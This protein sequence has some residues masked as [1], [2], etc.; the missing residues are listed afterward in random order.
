MARQVLPWVGAAVGF[1][2]S[3]GNPMGAQ[4]GFALGS[5]IGN[6]VDPIEVQGNKLGDSPTQTAAEGGARAIVFGKGCIRSTCVLERGGRRVIKQRDSSGGKGGSTTTV[7][8]RAL[9]TYA[10]GLGEAIPGGAILRIWEDEKLVYDVTPESQIPDDSAAFAQKFRFYDGSED[11][12]P[13]PAIEAIYSDPDDAPYYRGTAYMVF[14]QRD[15]TDFGERVPMYRVEVATVAN[16]TTIGDS[17]THTYT[18]SGHYRSSYIYPLANGNLGYAT[19]AD[20]VPSDGTYK[21]GELNSSLSVVNETDIAWS[22]FTFGDERLWLRGINEAGNGVSADNNSGYC[23][24]FTLGGENG[25]FLPA[26]GAANSWWYAEENYSPEFGGLVWFYGGSLYLGVRKTGNDGAYQRMLIRFDE[27]GGLPRYPSRVKTVGSSEGPFF[28]MTMSR[29]GLVH[30]IEQDGTYRRFNAELDEVESKPIGIGVTDLRG[31][32]V[33][34]DVIAMIYGAVIPRVE[35]RNIVTGALIKTIN[36]SNFSGNYAT[37][38][39]FTSNSCFIQCREWVGRIPYSRSVVASGVPL[40]DVISAIHQRAGHTPNDYDVGELVELIDGVV[41]EQT[42]TAA[43]A[44]NSIIGTHWADPTE[45]DGKIRY[46][47][48]GKPVVRTLTADD[49]IDEPETWQR[50]N[51]IEY[52]AKVHFFGQIAEA[53]YAPIKA[54]SSRSS[55]DIC[56]NVV[57]EA[58]ISSPETFNDSVRPYEIATIWHKIIW[59]EAGGEITWRVTDEHM[60]LVPSDC[61]GL[62]WRGQLARARIVQIEDDPGERKL[63]MRLDRQSA[64]TANLTE[65]PV[66]PPVTPPLTSIPA[67]TALAVLDIP[68]LTDSADSLVYYTAMS[69]E[70]DNWQGAVLQQSL[71]EGAS[72]GVVSDSNVNAIMGTLVEPISSAAEWYTDTTNAVIVDLFTEDDLESRSDTEFLRGGGAFALSYETGGN[73]PRW[74]ILQFRDAEQIGPKRWKLTTLHRG[75]KSTTPIAHVP[76]DMFVLLDNAVQRHAA[77]SAWIAPEGVGAGQAQLVHRAVSFGQSPEDADVVESLFLGRSQ[78]EW[79]VAGIEATRAGGVITATVTPRHRFGT[80][81]NPI[82]SANF[83]G[84]EWFVYSYP[85]PGDPLAT[86]TTGPDELTANLSVS[87]SGWVSVWCIARNRITGLGGVQPTQFPGEPGFS[88]VIMPPES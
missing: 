68:A 28:W 19:A 67:D 78:L 49:L 30:I 5:L 41:I 34:G 2:V 8:D 65:I 81:M 55:K 39:V 15:L 72:F 83:T 29:D 26:M 51:A 36:N 64:Y 60:D 86:A 80:P 79:P 54:T 84:F 1:V 82:P 47:K 45:Y 38:V 66:P 46:I 88:F 56:N 42:V 76:G 61:V 35:F 75:V 87:G 11:Q 20:G 62:S 57:G 27:T 4:A 53:A 18:M 14:P 33:D 12:L 16:E 22:G 85:T 74:E 58:S 31:F 3:G 21:K 37:R 25:Y 23:K 24:G 43:E 71:D 7:N 48:R 13:D 52:P 70:G 9:W 32:G 73:L 10:I 50:K 59:A 40:Y 6:T 17:V 63:R 77:E 69:G 44:I